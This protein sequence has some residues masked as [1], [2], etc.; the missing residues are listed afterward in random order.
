MR[1]NLKLFLPVLAAFIFVWGC[2]GKK[3]KISW[4][5]L[6][7]AEVNGDEKGDVSKLDVDVY[8]DVTTSMKGFVSKDVSNFGK[9]IDEIESTCQTIWRTTDIKYYKY[10]RT[11]DSIS[12]A[13]F[14][15]SKNS[16]VI[17]SDPRL[18]T[19]TN[20]AAAV[21]NTDTK[22]VSILITDL[23]YNKNDVNLVV[24]A[25][26][27]QVISKGIEIGVI[28]LS[29][30]FNG[31][32]ADVS[33]PVQVKGERPLYVL[34]FGDKRNIELLF[35]SLRNKTYVN[36]G[37]YLLVANKPSQGFEVSLQKDRT[38]K[39]I[40]NQSLPDKSWE[41]YGTVFNFRMKE[42]ETSATLNLDLKLDVNPDTPLFGVKNLKPLVFKKMAGRK[43]SVPADDEVKLVN[44]VLK[45]N[46]IK[47][48]VQL[49]NVDPAGQYAYVVYFTF[50]NTMPMEMPEWVKGTTADAYGQGVNENKTL[51]LSKLLTDVVTSHV[52]AR[53]P[54]IAKFYLFLEKK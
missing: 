19:Q 36:E 20:F 9:L 53:Q 1:I 50:D 34:V 3:E 23:F 8:L 16:P 35:N 6:D 45:G 15:S 32:V 4:G 5:N 33:P 40:N 10:G 47:A 48:D 46:Q 18:S 12:R 42:K 41:K 30:A 28:G 31:V 49:N 38:S 26:K 37:Q 13:E 43:D 22:R 27:E 44:M 39:S 25:I 2:D 51:N 11:V 52:T 21:R 29:S 54:K 17:F 7:K 14:V 24:S